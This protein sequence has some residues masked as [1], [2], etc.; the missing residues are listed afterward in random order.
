MSHSR[1]TDASPVYFQSQVGAI[2][3]V[4]QARRSFLC[5]FAQEHPDFRLQVRDGIM[6]WFARLSLLVS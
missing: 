3:A 6:Q 4:A 1:D 2:M 5:L